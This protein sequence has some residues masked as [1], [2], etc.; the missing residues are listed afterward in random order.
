M[1]ATDRAYRNTVRCSKRTSARSNTR[2]VR[3]VARKHAVSSICLLI[4]TNIVRQPAQQ[5]EFS[6]NPSQDLLARRE[7]L[8]PAQTPQVSYDGSA[9]VAQKARVGNNEVDDED[10]EKRRCPGRNGVVAD[11]EVWVLAVGLD[12][13]DAQE[14][15]HP[16]AC[17]DNRGVA[18]EDEALKDGVDASRKQA[19]W[20]SKEKECHNC[21]IFHLEA[22][23]QR[24]QGNAVEQEVEDIL[25]QQRVGVQTVD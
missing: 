19:K 21:A 23:K 22:L 15:E 3:V 11:F 10:D 20:S 8:D 6:F 17:A 12:R 25:V 4:H 16:D 7:E 18:A 1:S 14:Q 2:A 24:C 13:F 5:V 9:E